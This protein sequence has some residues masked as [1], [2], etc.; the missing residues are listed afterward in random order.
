MEKISKI[1]AH[2]VFQKTSSNFSTP[3]RKPYLSVGGYGKRDT[4]FAILCDWLGAR[5]RTLSLPFQ[6]AASMDSASRHHRRRDS[7]SE[8]K[9]RSSHRR[10]RRDRSR[11]RSRSPERKRERRKSR[12]HGSDDDDD[13][14]EGESRV[15]DYPGLPA[16]VTEL[17]Q[18]DCE[19]AGP[20]SAK[21][22]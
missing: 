12:K 22:S 14:G 18:D 20:C 7:P 13:G 17:N 2:K 4:L 19:L 1:S 9:D 5:V 21:L 3:S 8:Q 16:G 15:A 10:D 11:S 6:H